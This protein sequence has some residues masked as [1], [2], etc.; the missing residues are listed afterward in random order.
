MTCW[1]FKWKSCQKISLWLFAQDTWS[2][3]VGWL[4]L[5]DA[6]L[7][8]GKFHPARWALCHRI[9][10]SLQEPHYRGC[11]C[12]CAGQSRLNREPQGTVMA[13]LGKKG[14]DHQPPQRELVSK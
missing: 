6:K 14:G 8:A 5:G 10:A 2:F 11:G 4:V 9:Q 3:L 12:P 1:F 7:T 13:Q